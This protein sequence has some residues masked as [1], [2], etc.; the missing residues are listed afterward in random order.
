MKSVCF[1]EEQIKKFDAAMERL[2]KDLQKTTIE[3]LVAG[4][5]PIYDGEDI[6]GVAFDPEEDQ[7]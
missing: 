2:P 4:A 7:K 6:V 3:A 1:T 5:E